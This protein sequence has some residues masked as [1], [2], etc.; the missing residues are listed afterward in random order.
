M[1]SRFCLELQL[2]AMVFSINIYLK[3][4]VERFCGTCQKGSFQCFYLHS[5]WRMGGSGEESNNISVSIYSQSRA[6]TEISLMWILRK[7]DFYLA[8]T[9]S[10]SV[11]LK[12]RSDILLFIIL[13][14]CLAICKGWSQNFV[15]R[16]NL[17]FATWL[18]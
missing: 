13:G 16:T 15:I 5:G 7:T 14:I 8:I 10:N 17:F 1:L 2:N 3:K 9:L 6:F 11:W 4:I 18:I 12:D